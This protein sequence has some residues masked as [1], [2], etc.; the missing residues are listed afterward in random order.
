M[1]A[2]AN[3]S[4]TSTSV[5]NGIRIILPPV[6]A[7]SRLLSV[8][9]LR[10]RA[11]ESGQAARPAARGRRPRTIPSYRCVSAVANK[12]PLRNTPQ[13]RTEAQLW[14]PLLRLSANARNLPQFHGGRIIQAAPAEAVARPS[15]GGL[16]RLVRKTPHAAR[17]VR[18]GWQRR[19]TGSARASAAI[20]PTSPRGRAATV[21]PAVLLGQKIA[22]GQGFLHPFVAARRR[23]SNRC[24]SGRYSS[25]QRGR[26]HL[27]RSTAS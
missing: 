12:A 19:A 14:N 26:P 25:P 4:T 13:F 22:P 27:A 1:S 7:R 3:P 2:A 23:G 6:R 10:R 18:L 5:K 15:P 21:V 11:E 9:P 24:G 20:M 17:P 16:A 8:A